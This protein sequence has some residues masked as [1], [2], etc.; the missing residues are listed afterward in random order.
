MKKLVILLG[1]FV[2]L[3]GVF[4]SAP[5]HDHETDD[6]CDNNKRTNLADLLG[7]HKG[8]QT[9]K[10]DLKDELKERLEEMGLGVGLLIFVDNFL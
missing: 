1:I 8:N 3:F 2:V 5:A 7:L 4:Q 6:G 10:Q 9:T